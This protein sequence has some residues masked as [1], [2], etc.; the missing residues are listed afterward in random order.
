MHDYLLQHHQSG[1]ANCGMDVCDNLEH[2]VE[3]SLQQ[4]ILQPLSHCIYQC[5]EEYFSQSGHL[6]QLQ[7]SIH[8]NKSKSPEEMGIRVRV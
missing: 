8:H 3:T 2:V 5:I 7:H 1:L 4:C 6:V